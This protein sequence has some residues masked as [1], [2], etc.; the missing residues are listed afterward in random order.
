MPTLIN[1]W[2]CNRRR[3]RLKATLEVRWI[4]RRSH[5]WGNSCERA[6]MPAKDIDRALG[7]M[8]SDG[9]GRKVKTNLRAMALYQL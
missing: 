1:A 8:A 5:N 3:K 4:W 7:M 6:T 2:E 9:K